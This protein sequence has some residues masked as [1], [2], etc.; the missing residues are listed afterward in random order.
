MGFLNKIF[1][2]KTTDKDLVCDMMATEGISFEYND[3]KYYFCSEHCKKEFE[4]NP[5]KY[6]SQKK[7]A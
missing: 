6:S 2:K 5:E 3:K 4:Q 1:V 7:N